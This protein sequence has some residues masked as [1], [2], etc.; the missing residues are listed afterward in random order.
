MQTNVD[1][2]PMYHPDIPCGPLSG[3]GALPEWRASQ[4]AM[5][6]KKLRTVGNKTIVIDQIVINGHVQVIPK[7]IDT[8]PSLTRACH[9]D[10]DHIPICASVIIAN[11]DSDNN[12]EWRLIIQYDI[13]KV[14]DQEC[15]AASR[16]NLRDF[17]AVGVEVEN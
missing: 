9:V 13:S 16:A 10:K 15:A 3:N 6:E 5:A 11:S 17:L 8:D 2:Y 1:A 12:N 7:S 4:L 14:T